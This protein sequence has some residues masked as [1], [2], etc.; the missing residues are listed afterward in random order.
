MKRAWFR[1]YAELNDFLPSARKKISFP[2]EF[3]GNQLV[4]EAIESVGVPHP[5]VDLILA[6]GKSVGFGYRINDGDMISVYPVFESIDIADAVH[7]SGRPLRNT[8]FIA[9]VHLGKLTRYLRLCGFDTRIER[10]ADD[11]EIIE[12]AGT[13]KRIIL[14]RDRLLLKNKLVTRG[15]WIRSENPAEQLSEVVRRLQLWNSI[16]AFTRCM[17]CNGK[18]AEVQKELIIGSLKPQ[19]REYYNRF[20]QCTGCGQIYWEGSHYLKMKEFIEKLKDEC[21]K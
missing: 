12:I 10:E 13:G 17:E 7:L 14:T 16:A 11:P 1:F 5:E 9:D 2:F 3:S 20:M 19:T 21:V 18:L 15:L 8:K 4:K 6:N